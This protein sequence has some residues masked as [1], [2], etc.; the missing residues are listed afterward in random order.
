MAACFRICNQPGCRE[1]LRAF[2]FLIAIAAAPLFV[3]VPTGRA[4]IVGAERMATGLAQPV[5]VTHAPGDRD[6]LFVLTK[7]GQIR[8]IDVATKTLLP[9]P[10]LSISG[11]DAVGEGGLLGLAFHPDFADNGK[12]YVN[13]T[14]DNGGI[15][16]GGAVSPFSNEIREYQV[17]AN[18]NVAGT[19][20]NRVLS[21]VQPQDNHN[22]GWIGFSPV[23]NYLYIMSGDGGGSNDI[24][25]GHTSGTGNSQD[26]T[27][28]LLGK[29][30]RI[31]VNGDDFPD[32]ANRNYAIPAD[33]PFVGIT[34]DDE[35]F[36]Y[37]LRNP[38]RSSF[39]RATGD[40]WIGDVGQTAREEIN[41][42][43]A[44]APGGIN[45]G[46]RLREGTI[47]TPSGGVG[48]SAPGATDP[49]YEYPRTGSDFAGTSVTGG[50]IYRGPDPTLRGKYIFGDYGSGRYWMF[51]PADPIGTR[52]IISGM[53]IPDVGSLTSPVSFGEDAVGNLYIVNFGSFS[54]ATGSI[55]RIRT[56]A[57]VPGDFDADAS[58]D[59]DDLAIWLAGFGT[60]GGASAG[61]GDANGDGDVD[62][63][64][65]LLWQRNYGDSAL[66]LPLTASSNAVPEPT[67]VALLL[68]GLC[69]AGRRAGRTRTR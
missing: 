54:S 11:T 22:G 12:F 48:G 15:N 9:T 4:A 60:S 66:N 41:V 18:P 63:R 30:L 50:Y 52:Q 34:G 68:G 29:A 21:Y 28:N 65:F 8:I 46:W 3:A 16:L 37:G 17:T 55:Y 58:V 51:D 10:F 44:G 38:W 69:V 67:A 14:I 42:H 7:G 64:D 27:N 59:D 32:D 62:G 56:N 23:N 39:D 20:F 53:L 43:P 40:L 24:G 61:N 33:N 5:F 47:A 49:V 45:Y 36:D 19:S 26:I 31:D 2:R 6:R 25:N 57:L 35:I 1:L 13:V